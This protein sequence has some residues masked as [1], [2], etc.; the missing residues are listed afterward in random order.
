MDGSRYEEQ[1]KAIDDVKTLDSN[2]V[3]TYYPWVKI[4]DENK[5]KP[6]WVPPSVVLPGVYANNDRIGQEWFAPAG[7]KSWW[8]NRC[9]RSTNKTNQLRK[10]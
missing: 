8:F 1:F 9:V 2:Y 4:L 10:R 5:N 7:S 6:T 3:G